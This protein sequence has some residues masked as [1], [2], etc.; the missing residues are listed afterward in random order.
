MIPAEFEL[1]EIY[2]LRYRVEKLKQNEFYTAQNSY[3]E[4]SASDDGIDEVARGGV[5]RGRVAF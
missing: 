5:G 2:M 3:Q 1:S 4:N